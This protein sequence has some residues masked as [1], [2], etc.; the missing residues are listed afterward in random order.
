MASIAP[1]CRAMR[2]PR[3]V[4]ARLA[5]KVMSPGS[6]GGRSAWRMSIVTLHP[7][8]SATLMS[9]KSILPRTL[10]EC[11]HTRSLFLSLLIRHDIS[12][13]RAKPETGKIMHRFPVLRRPDSW[14]T[15]KSACQF[16][17]HCSKSEQTTKD[18]NL[19]IMP[20]IA[21]AKL[22]VCVFLVGVHHIVT[23]RTS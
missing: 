13:I 11:R 8:S 5:P 9:H 7:P 22:A 1:N 18:R 23:V 4:S 20:S 14:Q 3:S 15:L 12:S 17:P 16:F 2:H 19:S 21:F 10:R 6:S